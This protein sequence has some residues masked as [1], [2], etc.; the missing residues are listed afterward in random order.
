[1]NLHLKQQNFFTPIFY[2]NVK[3]KE[4]ANY[5]YTY[6]VQAA[7]QSGVQF[8]HQEA[9]DNESAKGAYHVLLPDG[10]TQV[11]EYHADEQGFQPQIR[12]E[13]TSNVQSSAGGL[14]GPY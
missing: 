4:P 11:V 14:E 10:R 7:Q 9:R 3:L 8:G 2:S 5:E 13:G 6:E 12:Y 1:M